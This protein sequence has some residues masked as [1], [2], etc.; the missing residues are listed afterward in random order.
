MKLLTTKEFFVQPQLSIDTLPFCFQLD[1]L[2]FNKKIVILYENNFFAP[3]SIS[4]NKFLKI[5]QFQF[6]PVDKIGARLNS[7]DELVFCE[8]AIKF[9]SDYKL[10]H[11]ILQP[12]NHAL[13]YTF[14]KQS[15]YAQFGTYQ[16]ELKGKTH[17]QILYGM[18]ARYRT[19]VRQI[20][21]LQVEIKFGLA[22]LEVF[23]KYHL[24][25][26][27]RTGAYAESYNELKNEL[28]V[29]PHNTLLATV[30]INK[31]FQGG[32]Y[33]MYSNYSAYYFH[34][35]S[36][37]TTLAAGA[38]KYLHYKI[39][40]LMADKGVS[41]YDFVGARLSDVKGTKLEGIQNFKKRFGAKLVKGFLW[42][43]DLDKTK[44]KVYD[45]LLKLKCKL[46][47]TKVLM[48]II[49]QEKDKLTVL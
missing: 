33:L 22:E 1:Y 18:Q 41:I 10:A 34:G 21:K 46:K 49:D 11:R 26:M 25:T 3:V 6:P 23:Q 44:C 2:N 24:E 17:A 15:N 4:K 43:I 30:Y 31:Q 45:D 16:I 28:L 37:N 19:A 29:L 9:I 36:A 39:M 5:L 47:G 12:K 27:G 35:A 32:L 14:P 13:F 20:E 48:D 38:I 40:C 8:H 7:E 42:K